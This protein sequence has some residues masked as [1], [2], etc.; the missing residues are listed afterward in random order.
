MN[1]GHL[2]DGG[3]RTLL[4]VDGQLVCDS[5]AEYG[6]KPEFISKAGA[7]GGHSHGGATTHI[8]GM[9]VCEGSKI[10]NNAMKR[11]Q[12][13]RLQADYDFSKFKGVLHDDGELDS[14]MGIQ[15]VYV[16]TDG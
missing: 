8:S 3:T 15:L 2:H 4:T 1:T 14:V 6:G 13:W 10:A 12:K 5:V 9:N 7:E 16:K 11:G